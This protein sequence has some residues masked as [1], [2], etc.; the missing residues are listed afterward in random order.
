MLRLRYT[1]VCPV[2][3]K[4]FT[5]DQPGE[6]TCT[7][8]SEMRHEHPPTLMFLHSLQRVEVDPLY[9]EQ[10]AANR[11]ILPDMERAIIGEKR[12]LGIR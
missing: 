9:A 6:P 4:L 5:Y 1:F 11:L 12:I 8:P 10:R 7:G 2:C 3:R